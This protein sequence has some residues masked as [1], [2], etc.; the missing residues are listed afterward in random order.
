MNPI[1][2]FDDGCPLCLRS[3][4]FILDIDGKQRFL[5][6]PLQGKTALQSLSLKP[7]NLLAQNSL[8]LLENPNTSQE[9]VFLRAKAVARILWLVGGWWKLL[10]WLCWI[11]FVPDLAYRLIA[12]HRHSLKSSQHSSFT[13]NERSRFLP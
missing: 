11:P 6:A 13:E 12:H 4:R 8:V 3:V 2:F 5:F 1:I 9:K 10:G 7:G